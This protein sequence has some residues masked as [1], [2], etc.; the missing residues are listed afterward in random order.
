MA[1]TLVPVTDLAPAKATHTTALSGS[2]NDLVFTAL[3]A[4]PGGN[5]IRIRYVVAG[6][7][8]PLTVVVE[9]LDITVNVAT[10]GAGAATSTATQVKTALDANPD[11]KKLITTALAASNDGTGVVAAFSFTNLAAGALGITEPA[12]TNGDAT[13]DH[14]F[15]GNDGHVV[16]EVVSSDGG[17]QT[18]TFHLNPLLVPGI[19]PQSVVESIPAGAT[20]RLG[21]F[22]QARYNQNAAKDVYFDPSVSNTLDFRACRL[23]GA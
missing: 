9:G 20:K 5:S 15:T 11:V 6:N 13:N 3:H 16:L 19:A 10:N 17:A 8:T 4:G 12:L 2:N 18:V 7:N 22:S 1:R 23:L 14:Y 21:P